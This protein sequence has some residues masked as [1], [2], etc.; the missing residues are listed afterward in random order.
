M[1]HVRGQPEAVEEARE[2]YFLSAD[3]ICSLPSHL[4]LILQEDVTP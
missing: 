2:N 4:Y 3:G 1:V